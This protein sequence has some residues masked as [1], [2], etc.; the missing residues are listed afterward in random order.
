MVTGKTPRCQ[1]TTSIPL[2]SIR[3]QWWQ[4][5]LTR[6]FEAMEDLSAQLLSREPND[7]QVR[8]A[9]ARCLA[10]RGMCEEARPHWLDLRISDSSDIEASYHS[11][12]FELDSG[13]DLDD[14]IDRGAPEAS[15]ALRQRLRAVLEMHSDGAEEHARHIAICGVS[16]CGSTILERLLGSLAGVRSIGES[17][18][19]IKSEFAHGHD[20]PDFSSV[21][22]PEFVPCGACGPTC[23]VFTPDF[24][25]ALAANRTRWY[26]RIANRLETT[27]LVSSD[28]NPPKLVDLDPLLRFS[29]LVMFKSPWQAWRSVLAR[30]P[31]GKDAPYYDIECEKYLNVW[32]NAYATLI[33][34]F[35]P[36]EGSS[37]LC[38][39]F[40]MAQP[41]RYL[42]QLCARFDLSFDPAVLHRVSPGHALGGNKNAVAKLHRDGY[43]LHIE[44]LPQFAF[45]RTQEKIVQEHARAQAVYTALLDRHGRTFP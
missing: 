34:R 31:A 45:S 11:S 18:L 2:S 25:L 29:A 9:L 14:A 26:F 44:P 21:T 30:L 4:A 6:N 32:S 12:K 7:Q 27:I 3:D 5:R 38:C 17:H 33:E 35:N 1:M 24:R 23:E 40:F 19:L 16:Y 36:A 39:D 42:S 15:S 20:S 41:A 13:R 28:K 37:Y 43:A 10:E 22:L 8:R